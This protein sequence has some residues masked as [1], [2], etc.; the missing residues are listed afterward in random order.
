VNISGRAFVILYLAY[1]RGLGGIT[2]EQYR[3][4]FEETIDCVAGLPERVDPD[5]PA[6]V[7]CV[8]ALR[9]P[10]AI[11]EPST[12][13]KIDENEPV[14]ERTINVDYFELSDNLWRARAHLMDNLHNIFVTLDVSTGDL[15]VR[16]A[17]LAFLRQPWREC[18]RIQSRMK[19]MIG[20]C[21]AADYRQRVR[22]SFVGM[23]GCGNAY[24]TLNTMHRGFLQFYLWRNTVLGRISPEQQALCR[25]GLKQD[26]I[27]CSL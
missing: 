5:M 12:R 22:E 19:K 8:P 23:E 10:G 2:A 9:E 26:C 18:D 17:N 27:A 4:F 14:F 20:V 6:P 15:V 1:Q 11:P 21:L 13:E 7:H 16:D 3:K 25:E 24:S